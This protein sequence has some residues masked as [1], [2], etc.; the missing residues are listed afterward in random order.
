MEIV[1]LK[2]LIPDDVNKLIFK[3]VGVTPHPQAKMLMPIYNEYSSLS[4]F[5][6]V[7]TCKFMGYIFKEVRK[8][9]KIKS[10]PE[11]RK[12]FVNL[13]GWKK[14]IYSFFFPRDFLP[15]NAINFRFVRGEMGRLGFK[16]IHLIEDW[17]ELK[18]YH[19]TWY[20]V[21]ED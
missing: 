15:L 3:F 7:Q 17:Y 20:G 11:R 21:E 14:D 13:R 9:I 18:Y 2:N 6:F 12:V 8:L 19:F 16:D 4:D 10:I 1:G 5:K